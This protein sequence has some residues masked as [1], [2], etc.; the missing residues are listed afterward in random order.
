[1]R[2]ILLGATGYLGSNIAA[3][4]INSGHEVTAIIRPT[5]NA[6]ILDKRVK[7]ILNNSLEIENELQRVNYDWVINSACVYK[8][9]DSFY[10]DMLDANLFFPA[11][12][13]NLAAKYKIA[14]YMTMGTSLPDKFNMYSFS[15]SQ[16]SSLGQFFSE[17]ENLLNFIELKLEMFYGEL[18]NLRKGGGVFHARTFR[19]IY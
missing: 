14:N 12:I 9:N 7:L 4:L 2:I 18:R 13:L 10:Y 11:K 19:T 8:Q 6:E 5:S 17:N 1:M 3:A 15:K 16:L